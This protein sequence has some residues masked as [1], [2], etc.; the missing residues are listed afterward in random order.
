MRLLRRRFRRLRLW[1]AARTRPVIRGRDHRGRA[2]E[3]GHLG[4][5]G[6][7][8]HGPRVLVLVL[9]F[10]FGFVAGVGWVLVGGM[11]PTFFNL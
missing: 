4:G 9:V 2:G 5:F 6:N 3:E 8:C 10:G 7:P 1:G 11:V